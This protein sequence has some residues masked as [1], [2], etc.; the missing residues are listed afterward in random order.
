MRRC[1]STLAAQSQKKG[2]H[3]DLDL[4]NEGTLFTDE[5]LLRSALLNLLSNAVEY[6]PI[7]G[8]ITLSAAL[9][10]LETRLPEALRHAVPDGVAFAPRQLT[11]S[12]R[13]NGPGIKE[14][15]INNIFEP[16]YRADA[17]RTDSRHHLGLGLAA[18]RLNVRSLGGECTVESPPRDGGTGCIFRIVLPT[19]MALA[20][21][22]AAIAPPDVPL[23]QE[24]A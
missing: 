6:T 3:V 22:A 1:I 23:A 4:H 21:N 10:E 20:D 18:V 13:D 16:F 12:V 14:E 5:G 19:A 15:Y 9:S 7:L 2:I 8:Q 11:L 24:S 17:S